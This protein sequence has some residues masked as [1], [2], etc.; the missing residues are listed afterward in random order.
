MMVSPKV[1]VIVPNYN[2][3]SY[4]R[5][6][7]ESIVNQTFQ[8]FELIL[9]DDCS[10]D[11]SLTILNE[12]LQHPKIGAFEF[13]KKNS[14]STF[15]QWNKGVNLAKGKY[16]WI[17]ESDDYCEPDFLQI[18]ISNMEKNEEVGLAY[19]ISRIVDEIGN[20][21]TFLQSSFQPDVD[22]FSF[23]NKSFVGN[24]KQLLKDAM[25]SMNIV[26]NASAVVFKRNLYLKIGGADESMKLYGD[27]LLWSK[28]LVD[29]QYYFH[30]DAPLNSFRVHT[31]TV[32]SKEGYAFQTILDYGKVALF[33]KKTFPD[34][35]AILFDKLLYVFEKHVRENKLKAE[36]RSKMFELLKKFN[37]LARFH[38]FKNKIKK[39]F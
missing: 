27:W 31:E 34:M 29:T 32:R 6:R 15:A 8:D 4:L 3:A 16:V 19:S 38:V 21:S 25:Y 2:H 24:G 7:L 23:F 1:S 18:L 36:D 22:S 5:R 39:I 33:I 26:P 28:M 14:G 10:T 17:A 11:D 30:A 20:E 37:K 13:S 35:N 12:Y 9:L